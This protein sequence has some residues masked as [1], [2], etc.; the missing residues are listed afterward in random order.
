MYIWKHKVRHNHIS[1]RYI[2]IYRLT[3]FGSFGHLR[4]SAKTSLILCQDSELV[5]G[6]VGQIGNS[7]SGVS[8]FLGNVHWLPLIGS[9]QQQNLQLTI[10]KNCETFWLSLGPYLS[11]LCDN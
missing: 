7:V 6:F 5:I 2:E 11:R 10:I 1:S 3:V 9:C 8:D 4:R